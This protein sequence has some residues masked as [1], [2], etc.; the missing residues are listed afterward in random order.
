MEKL[1]IPLALTDIEIR[2]L[3]WVIGGLFT[4][5]FGMIGW[6]VARSVGIQDKLTSAIIDLRLSISG[7]NATIQAIQ[8]EKSEFKQYYEKNHEELKDEVVSVKDKV[9]EHSVRL[10]KVETELNMA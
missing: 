10:G 6:F 5:M 2:V 1:M 9:E 7:V 3:M 8:D 4:I